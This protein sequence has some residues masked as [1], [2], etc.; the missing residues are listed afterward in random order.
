ML[1]LNLTQGE[2]STAAELS[3]ELLRGKQHRVVGDRAALGAVVLLLVGS[4][5]AGSYYTQ[6]LRSHTNLVEES[7][8]LLINLENI[9]SMLHSAESS[10]RGYIITGEEA[11][12]VRYHKTVPRINAQLAELLQLTQTNPLEPSKLTAL[13]AQVEQKLTELNTNMDVRRNESFTAAQSLFS[14]NLKKDT[15]DSIHSSIS[16]IRAMEM[17]SMSEREV[18]AA[19]TYWTSLAVGMV[20]TIAGLALV[21]SVVYLLQHNRRRAE[22]AAE[23]IRAEQMRLQASLDRIRRLEMDN[24]RMDQDM[25]S[26][27]EQVKDYAIFAMD[28]NCRATTWN[29]GVLEVLG[30]EEAEFI[31]QDIRQLIF[32]PEAIELGIPQVEFE[33]A[34]ELGSASDDRWMLRKGGT[35]FWASG[36][37]SAIRDD[38]GNV[39]G[40]SKVM[41]DLTDQKR[42]EDELAALAAKHS[43]SSRRMSEFMATLAHELRNP[44]APIRN[45]IDLMGM[46]SLSPENEELRALLDRQVVHV[47][48]LI[49]DLLDVSRIGR[50]KIV[51]H[52]KIVDLRS[53]IQSAIEAS[54][55]FI[56]EKKQRLQLNICDREVQVNVD[57][58]RIIQVVSNLLNNS[59]RYTD[60]GGEIQFT[61]TVDSDDCEHGSA[62][63][64]IRDN[65]IGISADRLDEIFQMFAQVDD[66]L[67]RGH[68]GLGIGLTLVKTLVELHRG[69]VIAQSDG[70]GHG[71]LF[72][73]RIPLAAANAEPITEEPTK[74]WPIS[75]RTFQVLVVEDMRALRT[76]MARLLEKLGHRVKVAED[77]LSALESII[78][79]T[80]EVVFSDISMPGMT[81][82][83]LA[84][85]I[86]KQPNLAN[87]YLVAMSGYGQL[88]DRKQSRD[89]GFNEHMVKPVDIA[90]LRDFFE[91][92]SA[93]HVLKVD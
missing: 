86:R 15:M 5:I 54:G 91:R 59:S 66:S 27:V 52:R 88:S 9:E 17:R 47:I 57:P 25:R 44:L 58:A 83:D 11:F 60:Q 68:A 93:G 80:P 39:V 29:N 82:Y 16:E 23:T 67:G 49:D 32:V 20:A 73:V 90:K 45:A 22:R 46:S 78:E 87:T 36:I 62:V 76:I 85:R 42:D 71:S 13:K 24:S 21:V 65:G 51:L 14:D 92:I 56:Q 6:Q 48:R 1:N 74:E 3:D 89:S 70:V 69:T 41:R 30:F 31:G 18:A 81:G 84:T 26:F 40:F 19:S 8:K 61:L 7:H 50:G 34:A 33:T 12:F 43:E 2:P 10:Q 4:G 53:V 75:N 77:G 63:M 28:E 64:S 37:T 79:V 38:Q 72:T 55:T 35:R